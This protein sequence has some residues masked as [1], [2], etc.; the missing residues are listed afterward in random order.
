MIL[1]FRLK[2]MRRLLK[3]CFNYNLP[4]QTAVVVLLEFTIRYLQILMDFH[5]SV[6]QTEP[7][8]P[9]SQQTDDT[10]S[11]HNITHVSRQY[12]PLSTKQHYYILN[13]A[14]GGM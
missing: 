13:I 4:G 2:Y 12:A 10:F 9:P 1:K 14:P 6:V 11:L 8:L 5:I 7:Q 3:N